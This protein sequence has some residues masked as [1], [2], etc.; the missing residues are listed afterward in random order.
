[1][2]KPLLKELVAAGAVRSVTL[3]GVPGGFVVSISTEGGSRSLC[4]QRGHPRV[5]KQLN[6]AAEFLLGIGV[7]RFAV[8]AEGWSARS[9]V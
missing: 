4:A 6:S 2:D 7:S 9:L 1:M 3:Y 5:F 8:E